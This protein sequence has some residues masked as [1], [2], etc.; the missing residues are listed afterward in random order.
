MKNVK[1][2]GSGC[3]R[4]KTLKQRVYLAIESLGIEA[5]VEEIADIVE[6]IDSGLLLVPP[7]LMVDGVLK[8]S[9]RLPTV[10]EI[11]KYLQED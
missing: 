3:A 9:G 5:E 4:C 10:V 7:A 8:T 1:V 2:Y 11:Q 6:I